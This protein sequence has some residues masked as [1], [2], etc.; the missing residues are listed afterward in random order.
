MP[1]ATENPRDILRR[2]ADT[3]MAIVNAA[4]EDERGEIADDL[5][6]VEGDMERRGREI[7]Q[8]IYELLEQ[9]AVASKDWSS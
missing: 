7:A 1:D 5:I 9:N 6:E 3:L 8:V 2:Y 4:T